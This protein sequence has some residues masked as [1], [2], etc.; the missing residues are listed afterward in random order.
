[1]SESLYWWAHELFETGG[2][3]KSMLVWEYD[4]YALGAASGSDLNFESYLRVK[5]QMIEERG[6]LHADPRAAI[7][8]LLSLSPHFRGPMSGK[9]LNNI[10]RLIDRSYQYLSEWNEVVSFNPE[11]D[12]RISALIFSHMQRA[13][14]EDAIHEN[15][16]PTA[17]HKKAKAFLEFG[18][19]V[20]PEDVFIWKSE[21]TEI[22]LKQLKEDTG[23]DP[24]HFLQNK[25]VPDLLTHLTLG[26]FFEYA[27]RLLHL[28][29][30]LDEMVRYF[31]CGESWQQIQDDTMLV[32]GLLGYS[33]VS[34]ARQRKS[35]LTLAFQAAL[36]EKEMDLLCNRFL[37][38]EEPT[39]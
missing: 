2:T 11:T 32:R 35:S 5:A 26:H 34:A 25:S 19:V 16:P 27:E 4:P 18:A 1:M 8:T 33:D 36:E 15:L 20:N 12:Y 29:Y 17:W 24:H 23:E 21:K 30:G 31:F 39:E 7:G 13:L 6:Y 9:F 14:L 37:E 38:L 3:C 22:F 10:H 28:G